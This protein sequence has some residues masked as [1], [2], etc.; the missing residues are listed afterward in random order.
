MAVR[1]RRFDLE[2]TRLVREFITRF[3]YG[4]VRRFFVKSNPFCVDAQDPL[5][6]PSGHGLSSA[7]SFLYST[8]THVAYQGLPSLEYGSWPQCISFAPRG[9][10]VGD[11]NPFVVSFIYHA[12][13]VSA[14]CHL[15]ADDL[16][17]ESHALI[18]Q[19]RDDAICFMRQFRS[20][21]QG[22]STAYTYGF[23]PYVPPKRSVFLEIPSKVLQLQAGS[24]RLGGS[25]GPVNIEFYPRA[26]QLPADADDTACVWA[27]LME[28][29]S[30]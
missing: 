17:E 13:A 5:A 12:L 21:C 11:L 18:R 22:C 14:N 25:R 27:A 6:T 30:T 23:W 15:R 29:T 20:T 7:I 1:A 4:I 28:H 19:M 2:L 3:A 24:L 10:F 9:P 16:S 8:Q 26:W